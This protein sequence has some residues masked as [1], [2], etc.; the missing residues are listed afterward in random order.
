MPHGPYLDYEWW[1]GSDGFTWQRP[2]RERSGLAGMPRAFAYGHA[3]PVAVDDE[4]RWVAGRSVYAL[5]RRRLF[6]AYGR[7]NT[8]AV[9]P[10]FVLS[11]EPLELEVSFEAHRRGE[12]RGLLQG[13]VMAELLDAEG[14]TVP[15]FTR[16]A[17]CFE[18]DTRTRLTLRWGDRALPDGAAGRT[19]RLR[20]CFRDTRLYSLT[21]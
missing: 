7:A 5:D 12:Q 9:T 16:D 15:G 8:E 21:V 14:R 13:Y 18:A 1:I 10:P 2:Y 3:Q 4:M 17:C 11:G 20:L 6:Y 19:A